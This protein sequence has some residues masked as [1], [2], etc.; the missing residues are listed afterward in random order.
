MAVS[1][2]GSAATARSASASA[3]LSIEHACSEWVCGSRR[4]HAVG[5]IQGWVLAGATDEYGMDAR[6]ESRLVAAIKVTHPLGVALLGVFSDA[7]GRRAV[8]VDLR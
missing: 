4:R 2:S 1:A 7:F 3:A 6:A 5:Q 8:V